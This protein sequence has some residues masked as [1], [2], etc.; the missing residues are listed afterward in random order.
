MTWLSWIVSNLLLALVLAVA[1][2]VMQRRLR[3]P[4]VAHLL[5]VLALVKLVTPPLVSVPLR[6]APG[7]LACMLGTCGCGSHVESPALGGTTLPW[8]LLAVWAT[9]ATAT[10]WIA[11]RRWTQ[12]RRL[13]THAHPAPAAWQGLAAR[14][15]AELSLRRP[16]RILAVPGRLPP[17]VIPGRPRP[18]L[19]LPT[20]LMEQLQPAQRSALLLHELVHLQRGDHLV[21]LLE[22]LVG[23]AYWW[24]PFVGAIGRQLRSCEEAC[25]DTAVVTR[26][27]QARRAYAQLLLDVLDFTSP[28]AGQPV[29]QATAM[30]AAEGLEQRL[31]TI[32][33]TPEGTGRTGPAWILALA[34]ACVIL[35]CE[36][37]YLPLRPPASAAAA[38]LCA[39]AESKPPV[40]ACCP[41]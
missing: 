7:T 33:D 14:L 2:W 11:W 19:L 23:I 40:L 18:L 25:C 29:P 6:A 16:P 8:M 30:S 21:R 38:D 24:L 13:L 10:A 15:A 34:L 3:R 26:R 1:A 39:P 20:A 41:S 28:L 35:P 12:L 32:L 27:P 37:R 31:L 17:L 9:G 36:F 4:A 5:W 22:L